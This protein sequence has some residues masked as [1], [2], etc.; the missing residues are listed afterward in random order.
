MLSLK[1]ITGFFD[2][3]NAI[4]QQLK[5]NSSTYHFKSMFGNTA[6]AIFK[7]DLYDKLLYQYGFFVCL[8]ASTTKIVYENLIIKVLLRIQK[9]DTR[10]KGSVIRI[11][12]K[13]QWY[14]IH[15]LFYKIFIPVW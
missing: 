11:K 6:T 8:H 9:K 4:N 5:V 15:P 13:K 3:N 12:G 14:G 1:R 10:V 7:R 2:W